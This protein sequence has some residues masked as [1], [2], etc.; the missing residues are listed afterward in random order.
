[1]QGVYCDTS[2][3]VAL[4]TSESATPAIKRWFARLDLPLVSA[5]WSIAEFHSAIAIKVRTCQLTEAQATETLE[6]FE[7]LGAG[8][9]R[10]LPV[11]RSAFRAAAILVDDRSQNLRGGD[12]L[13]LA[14]VQELGANRFATLDAN[15][16]GYAERL[17]L[18]IEAF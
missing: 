15:Q 1:M 7:Q 18:E 11:S 6:L 9:L 17:G 13:H 14:V 16:R 12:A 8:S 10:W 5:D 2:V 4:L 3:L